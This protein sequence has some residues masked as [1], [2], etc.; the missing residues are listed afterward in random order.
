[1]MAILTITRITVRDNSGYFT[2]PAGYTDTARTIYYACLQGSSSAFSQGN[3]TRKSS[4]L[5]C[6]QALYNIPTRSKTVPTLF[7]GRL[8]FISFP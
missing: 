5:S 4:S 3:P 7:L 2:L 1:M 8:F 6:R